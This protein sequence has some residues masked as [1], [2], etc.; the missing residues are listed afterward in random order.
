MAE[1]SAELVNEGRYLKPADG[2]PVAGNRGVGG[3]LSDTQLGELIRADLN[4]RNLVK[5][6]AF[7]QK[8]AVIGHG[9]IFNVVGEREL[10][11]AAFAHQAMRRLGHIRRVTAGVDAAGNP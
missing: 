10:G 7:Q 5:P 11:D 2:I 8:V 6:Q 3:R 4:R 9:R 1:G